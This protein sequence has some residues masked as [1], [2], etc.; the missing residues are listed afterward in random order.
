[1]IVKNG[2][3]LKTEMMKVLSG[4]MEE[5]RKTALELAKEFVEDW[6]ND[7]SPARYKRTYQILK[8]CISTDIEIRGTNLRFYVL[9]DTSKMHHDLES[10][11]SEMDILSN[12]SK[13]IHGIKYAQ[14]GKTQVKL[15]EQMKMEVDSPECFYGEFVDYLHGKGFN[16]FKMI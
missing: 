15:W 13:G 16:D 12:A 11:F 7:Y 6:Y 4:G 5:I 10:S 9:I 2:Q 14:K 3:E 8:N 1:M